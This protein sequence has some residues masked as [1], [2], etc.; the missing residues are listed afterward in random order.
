MDNLYRHLSPLTSQPEC[1]T[2]RLCEEHVGLVYVLGLEADKARRRE[3]PVMRTSEGVEYLGRTADGWCASF[4]PGSGKCS[5]YEDRPLC[6]RIYPL[7]LMKLD[8]ELWWVIHAE[9]PIAQR[10]RREGKL[11][12][13][14]AVTA[15]LDRELNDEQLRIW[16]A[17]DKTSQTIEAF[18]FDPSKVVKLRRFR[19][20]IRFLNSSNTVESR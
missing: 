7:D 2:C 13:L 17:Q 14:A 18:T 8:N 20:Q 6:C 15:A 5:M 10:F 1:N 12:L 3:L 19:E 16:I 9:C 4:D 11:T